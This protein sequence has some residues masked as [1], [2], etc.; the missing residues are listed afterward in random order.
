MQVFKL[1]PEGLKALRRNAIYRS[2]LILLTG[3]GIGAGSVIS[4]PNGDI[5]DLLFIVPFMLL[6]VGV[7][8]YIGI[9]KQKTL[10][11]SYQLTIDDNV[12]TREQSNFPTISIHPFEL[13]AIVKKANGS[14]IVNGEKSMILI[15]K[16]I[17]RYSE[18]ET[19]LSG[20]QPVSATLPFFQKY[21]TLTGIISAVA[22]ACVYL[23][24]NKL[25]VGITGSVSLILIVWSVIEMR[26]TNT[27]VKNMMWY[28]VIA[29]GS[30]ISIML[31]KLTGFTLATLFVA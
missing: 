24:D 16:E 19:I 29:V 11:E 15:P 4:S 18:I 12:I 31:Y 13:K 10:L 9:R 26:R 3:G 8:V 6:V 23:L 20:I 2:I 7:I 5:S 30:L 1:S 17:E 22:F 25:I 14:F 28:S 27:M 21:A